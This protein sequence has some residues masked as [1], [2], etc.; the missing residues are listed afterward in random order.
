M[1]R[2]SHTTP[3]RVFHLPKIMQISTCPAPEDV[4]IPTGF[5]TTNPMNTQSILA[6]ITAAPLLAVPAVAEEPI[7]FE[8]SILPIFDSKCLKCHTT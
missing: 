3:R 5:T 6:S 7:S 8:K 4:Y 2:R 1:P